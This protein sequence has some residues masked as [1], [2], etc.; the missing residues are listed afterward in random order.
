MFPHLEIRDT[1]ERWAVG[2][3]DL[4]LRAAT[5]ASNWSVPQP[6]LAPRRL[7]VLR[8]ERIGD[9]LMAMPAISALRARAPG[10][11]LHLVVGEW[12]AELARVIPGVS[13]V[14][15]VNAPWLARGA[16]A[17]GP[18][19][20]CRRGWRWRARGFDLAVNLEPDI[21]S[22]ALLG[23]SGASSRVGYASGGGAAF[24]TRTLRY[25]TSAHTAVN[26]MRLVDAAL[27]GS[28]GPAGQNLAAPAMSLHVADDARRNVGV[29]LTDAGRLL[30]G[31]NP[32]GGRR[33]KQWA[34]ERFGEVG[35]RLGRAHRAT[36]VLVG[37]VE[38]RGI[39]SAV[40][41]SIAEDV[42]VIDLSG[43]LDLSGL[44]ALSERLA[45]LIT[46]D[47]GPMHLAAAVGTPIVAIFGPSSPARYA[48]LT[49][50]ARVVRQPLWCRPC[51]RIRRPPDRCADRVPD[52]LS[53]IGVDDVCQAA[54]EL[55]GLRPA[56]DN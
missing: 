56:G 3:M 10:A 54:D 7:L 41:A 35:T 52:C 11:A 15:C 27:P 42:R 46:G 26:A 49:P 50:N 51:D 25:D 1:R 40:R 14:E 31:I 53:M 34:A 29:H 32:S 24:L 22:N 6:T 48:P 38:D 2:S 4:L 37:A 9:L 47:T 30:V 33:V 12:N 5:A 44:A 39:V 16:P 20:L 45:L 43:R 28:P 17:H 8:L 55:L 21:R 19:D 36:I 23:L 13:S 18:L